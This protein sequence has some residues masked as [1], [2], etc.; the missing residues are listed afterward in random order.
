[1]AGD[2]LELGCVDGQELLKVLDLLEEVLGRFS[3]RAYSHG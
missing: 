1:V 2:F 3:E